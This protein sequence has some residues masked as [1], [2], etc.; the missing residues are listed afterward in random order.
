[1]SL[2]PL[3]P[4]RGVA[5]RA[6]ASRLG[7]RYRSLLWPCAGN[8][9]EGL[10]AAHPDLGGAGERAAFACGSLRRFRVECCCVRTFIEH[11]TPL[12]TDG[13]AILN[14]LPNPVLL[15]APDGKIVDANIAAE[16]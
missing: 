4:A 6:K 15:V 12:P 9:I 7:A 14:A 1:R 10:A 13:E 3:R 2:P 5:P 16:S 8:D 11:R